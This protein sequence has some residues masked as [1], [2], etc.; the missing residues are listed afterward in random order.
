MTR[1]KIT[2]DSFVYKENESK[3]EDVQTDNIPEGYIEVKLE[4]IGKLY[5]PQILHFKDYSMENLTKLATQKNEKYLDALIEVLNEL[6]Y[7]DFDCNYLHEEDAKKILLLIHGAFWG[8]TLQGIPYY[9][10]ENKTIPDEDE[11]YEDLF[12]EASIPISSI[13]TEPLAKEVKMPINIKIGNKNVKFIFPYIGMGPIAS[14]ALYHKYAHEERK[15]SDFVPLYNEYEKLMEKKEFK[16]VKNL[17][18]C[19]DDIAKYEEFL[20][21]KETD[22]LHLIKAQLIYGID[23][24]VFTTLEEKIKASK[25]LD[26]RFWVTYNNII[27]K[28]KFG[29]NP[30]V[31]FIS[32]LTSKKI[33]R[34]FE[35]RPM[36]LLPNNELS[37]DSGI[38]VSFGN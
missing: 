35:F 17:S 6:V 38:D 30:E 1:K 2:K 7:E 13:K 20:T 34:R 33:T 26:A 23:N 19:Q 4:S 32:E 3:M 37:D 22:M 21:E 24:K 25:S 18:I 29:I 12:G 16:K 11:K 5:A 31:E 14:G 10:D 15:F 28:Y 27:K 36:E 9:L 8:G